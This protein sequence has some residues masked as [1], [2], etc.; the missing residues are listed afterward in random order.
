[1]KTTQQ[2][3]AVCGCR[4]EGIPHNNAD[5][6]DVTCTRAKEYGRSR[7]KQIEAEVRAGARARIETEEQAPRGATGF[8]YRTEN[9]YNRP[10]EYAAA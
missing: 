5:T 8:G 10:Y 6:C 2:K 4:I 7:G 3:C 9:D 1:M